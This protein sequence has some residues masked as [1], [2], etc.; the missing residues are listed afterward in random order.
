MMKMPTTMEIIIIVVL[1]G[2]MFVGGAVKRWSKKQEEGI[3]TGDRTLGSKLKIVLVMSCLIALDVVFA[4]LAPFFMIFNVY[5]SW[6]GWA[7]LEF[8]LSSNWL[9]ILQILGCVFYILGYGIYVAGR[10]EL[11]GY[12]AEMWAPAKLAEGFSQTGIFSRMRHPL[13]A[14][15]LIFQ[16]G[17]ILIFQTWLGLLLFIPPTIIMVKQTLKE[18]EWLI[19]RFGNEYKA[20]MKKTWRF[21]PKLW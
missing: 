17:L 21:F 18:E 7:S 9:L 12:F 16:I 6:L 19:K 3:P 5:H 15:S 20:Y 13:Y 2:S 14:G 8:F 10:I 1:L 4:F 11:R